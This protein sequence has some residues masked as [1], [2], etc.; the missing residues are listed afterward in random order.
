VVLVAA[1]H[2]WELLD[3]ENVP[4]AFLSEAPSRVHGDLW[5]GNLMWTPNQRGE[6][7]GVLIDPAAHTGHREEDLAMLM[8]FGAP[9]FEAILEGYNLQAPLVPGFRERFALHNIYPLLAHI[10]F[11]DRSYLTQVHRNLD[12]LESC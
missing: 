12:A 1:Y 5:S 7:E 4:R 2:D 11:Y 10:A 3:L 9:F 8:L 6:I